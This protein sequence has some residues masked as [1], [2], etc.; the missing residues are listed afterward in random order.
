[1]QQQDSHTAAPA[2]LAEVGAASA[3]AEASEGEPLGRLA[4]R[5]YAAQ[6]RSSHR[7]VH[8]KFH[9]NL[10]MRFPRINN[11]TRAWNFAR[12]HAGDVRRQ[13]GVSL[14]RQAWQL[15]KLVFVY[16]TDP[17]AYYVLNLYEPPHRLDEIEHYIGRMESKNGLYSLM[18]KAIVRGKTMAGH[19]LTNKAIFADCCAKAGLA[20]IGVIA[21]GEKGVFTVHDE[22]PDAFDR[23]L[24]VKLTRSSGAFG[25][26]SYRF[27]DGRYVAKDG[28]RFD[29]D[30]LFKALAKSSNWRPL[31]VNHW[32]HNHPEI[33]DLA[34]DS[35]LTFRVITCLDAAGQP[36][37]THAFMRIISKLEP[38]WNTSEEYGSKI[39]LDTGR[40]NR[41]CADHDL[42][43]DS[44][45]DVQPN[46]G[47]Q[48][49]GR[50]I[51]EWPAIAALALAAHREFWYW[52]VVGWDLAWTADGP[53]LIEGNSDPDTQFLQRVHRQPL[54]Q[55][56]MA[57]YL[58]HHLAQAEALLK[59]AL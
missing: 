7:D 20:H 55:S 30:G 32:L 3:G 28:T 4:R 21:S 2:R 39:D 52:A 58:R 16:R 12:R 33:A 46:T 8:S 45:W 9:K 36:H 56:P 34:T 41:M 26:R 43:P 49:T 6:C 29:R 11:L 10:R 23:D 51:S 35:L 24:F 44:W 54:G 59:D 13:H 48:V 5:L 1:M 40:M 17:G 22:A 47:A 27:E 50:V 14:L 19:S 42:A 38:S 31:I 25:A 57:P 53:I 37:V 18:R 15:L